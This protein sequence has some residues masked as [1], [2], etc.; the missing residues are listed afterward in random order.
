MPESVIVKTKID[1]VLQ[2]AALGGGAYSPTTG[3]LIA[4][5]KTYTV[6][7]EAGDVS[8]TLPSRAVNHF[9]D[10]GRITS[11]PSIRYGDDTEGSISF[12]A[13]LRDFS[14]AAVATLADLLATLSGNPNGFLGSNWES[15]RAS[16]AGAGDAEVFSVGCKLTI[17]NAGDG[18]DSHSICFNYV[19]GGGSLSEGDPSSFSFTGTIHDP[20]DGYFIG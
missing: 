12:S 18:T 1:G 5:A 9:K 20:V 19:V 2:F 6:A 16:A 4:A 14:D 13:Y 15:T 7:F 17:T 3:A 8:I 11:P 10:R